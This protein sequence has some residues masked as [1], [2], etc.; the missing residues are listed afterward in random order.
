MVGR[1]VEL[2]VHKDAPKLGERAARRRRPHRH[3]RHGPGRRRRRHLRGARG[4]DRS[5]S[6]VCR[7]TGRPSS[8]RRSS[9]CSSACTGTITL[10]GSELVGPAS[11]RI[12]DAGVGFVPED[13]NEDGLVGEFTIAE[14]LMLDRS[15][16]APVRQGGDAAARRT[17]TSS[18][19]EKSPS[20][21]SARRASTRPSAASPAAT[22]RRSCSRAS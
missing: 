17:S 4:R 16:G 20:S 11:A 14:N 22:S 13:R 9:A 12:L 7:A 5:P 19:R 15:D 21:T 2:T 6:P 1:A 3:R 10:N 18:R 8:P